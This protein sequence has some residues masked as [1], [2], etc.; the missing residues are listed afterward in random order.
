VEQRH[1][2]ETST[3]VRSW[4]IGSDQVISKPDEPASVTRTSIRRQRPKIVALGQR[5]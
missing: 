1:A 5:Q 3:T 2:M 4:G